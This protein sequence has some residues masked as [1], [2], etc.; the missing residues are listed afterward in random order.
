MKNKPSLSRFGVSMEADLLDGFDRLIARKGYAT[1]SEALRDMIRGMLAEEALT[2]KRA[3][4]VATVSLVYDHQVR[5]LAAKLTEH[6][7]RA[8]DLI[9]STVHIHLDEQHCLEVLIARG[10]YG[11]VRELAEQLISVKGVKHGKFV[12]TTEEGKPT[13]R[14]KKSSSPHHHSH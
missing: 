7:H 5:D 11:R 4:A 2:D 9:A 1:R 14:A 12:T 8:L 13:K 3:E 10:P 6:Q